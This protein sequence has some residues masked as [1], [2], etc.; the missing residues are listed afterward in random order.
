MQEPIWEILIYKEEKFLKNIGYSSY[1]KKVCVN[2]NKKYING[3]HNNFIDIM[4]SIL[5]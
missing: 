5:I 3:V 1:I 2:S 4:C